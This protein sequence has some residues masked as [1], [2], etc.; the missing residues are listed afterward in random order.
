[1]KAWTCQAFRPAN[2]RRQK[3][4]RRGRASRL[5]GRTESCLISTT[6]VERHAAQRL[7]VTLTGKTIVYGLANQLQTLRLGSTQSLTLSR[8]RRNGCWFAKK[9][10]GTPSR[11]VAKSGEADGNDGSRAWRRRG[12]EMARSQGHGT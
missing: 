5:A 11:G 6:W 8:C 3:P 10:S 2:C 12:Q 4:G 7:F 9:G 1:R